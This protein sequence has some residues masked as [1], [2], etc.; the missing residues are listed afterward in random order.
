MQVKMRFL[1]VLKREYLAGSNCGSETNSAI[2]VEISKN[3]R[4]ET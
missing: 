1:G 2:V 4:I 3:L